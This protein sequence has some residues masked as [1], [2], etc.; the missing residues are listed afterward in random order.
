[1][2]NLDAHAI[3]AAY[4]VLGRYRGYVEK[5]DLIQEGQVWIWDHQDKVQEY[6]AM[7]SK[8]GSW[9]LTRSL[10]AAMRRYA[11][12][13]KAQRAG[14]D[15]V[16]V[17][18]YSS[19]LIEKYLSRAI[20]EDPEPVLS[21]ERI[22]SNNVDPALGGSDLA[23]YM[24]VRHAWVTASLSDTERAVLAMTHDSGM[25]QDA[26]GALLGITQQVVSR[27]AQ[28]AVRKLQDV[29]GGPEPKGC[30]YDCECH[31]GRLRRRPGPVPW[32]V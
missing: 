27:T 25:S 18:W 32:G 5:D 4:K 2:L 13:M 21:G 6:L 11:E 3:N 31:E 7:E 12:Q 8:L 29:L 10:V 19:S 30:P 16:D 28:R 15:P 24:D 26:I 22:G 17:M 14:Y 20:S 1:M 23:Q 9:A